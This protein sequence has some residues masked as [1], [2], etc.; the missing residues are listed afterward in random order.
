MSLV[1]QAWASERPATTAQAEL[2]ALER[3]AQEFGQN[4]GFI[5]LAGQLN[6]IFPC[7]TTL[8]DD[9]GVWNDGRLKVKPPNGR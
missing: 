5:V 7:L 4:P 3:G 1:I 9:E 2:I 6:A 8:P